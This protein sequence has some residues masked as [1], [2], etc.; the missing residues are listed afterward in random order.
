MF[1]LVGG[2]RGER[3]LRLDP[4]TGAVRST[5]GLDRVG[6]DYGAVV[7]HAGTVWAVAGTRLFRL[8][9]TGRLTGTVD[10]GGAAASVFAS[11]SG[12]WVTHATGRLGQLVRVD[13]RSKRVVA[14]TQMG[15]G[16]DSVVAA[17]GSIW[18]ANTSPASLMRIDPRRNR[19]VATLWPTRF[20][21][22][23]ALAQ[24]LVWVA[25]ERLLALDAQGRIVHH[26]QLPRRVAG[27]AAQHDRLW[28]IDA[29]GCLL[30]RLLR[31]DLPQGPR[32]PHQHGRPNPGL[33]GGRIRRDLGRKLRG[34][35]PLPHLLLRNAVEGQQP[36][37]RQ[38]CSYVKAGL[39]FSVLK[40]TRASWR[41]RQRIASRRLLPCAR[42]RSR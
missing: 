3:L 34:L 23:L 9:A 41:L 24:G 27:L 10:V 29:C 26:A 31:I 18:V 11:R 2:A 25:G 5:T 12:V 38:C 33:T 36:R 32:E 42:L 17:L 1:V 35:K 20:A 19:V 14:R 28:A 15:G 7:V 40:T 6:S 4:V 39:A 16:P 21:S 13:P 8:S 30:G 37:L 22:A